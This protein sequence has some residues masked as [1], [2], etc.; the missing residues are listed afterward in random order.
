MS[1][2]GRFRVVPLTDDIGF[3]TAQANDEG[4][5]SIFEQQL[6]SLTAS[7]DEPFFQYSQFVGDS[8]PAPRTAVL[9]PAVAERRILINALSVSSGAGNTYAIN[10]I[11]ELGRDPRG[12]RF[13][14]LGAHGRFPADA[15]DGLDVATGSAA[16]R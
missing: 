1:A 4:Y 5:D 3:I 6:R 13:T 12:F 16:L 9:R 15:A 11:R 2:T 14:V 7:G 8:R 10:L